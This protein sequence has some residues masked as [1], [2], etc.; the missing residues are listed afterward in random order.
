MI[1][2]NTFF[3]C[4]IWIN[5]IILLIFSKLILHI[6][7]K[8]FNVHYKLLSHVSASNELCTYISVIRFSIISLELCQQLFVVTNFRRNFF[9][10]IMRHVNVKH[11]A[12]ANDHANYSPSRT[13][14]F[15]KDNCWN[16]KQLFGLYSHFDDCLHVQCCRRYVL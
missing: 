1:N 2:I 6:K 10:F 5:P 16:Q 12:R 7:K 11:P 4:K 15:L 3:S 13:T 14:C 8:R 9:T